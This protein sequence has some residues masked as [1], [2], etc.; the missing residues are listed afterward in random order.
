MINKKLRILYLTSK[1]YPDIGGTEQECRN[2]ATK[3]KE[4]GHSCI[5][6]TAY[7]DELPA[8]ELIDGIP[9]YRKIRGWHFFEIT[10][11]LSVFLL[12]F[13]YRNYFDQL[14]CFGFARFT[15]PAVVF[16]RLFRKKIYYRIESPGSFRQ[17][18]N[19]K[20]GRL[21]HRISRYAHGAIVFNKEV[22]NMLERMGFP[23]K[24]IYWIPNSVDTDRFTSVPSKTDSSVRFCFVGRLIKIKGLDFFIEALN[25]LSKKTRY[26]KVLI[27]GDGEILEALSLQVEQH[28]LGDIVSFPGKTD[29][30]L[31]YYQKSDVFVLP[32]VSEG[33]PLAM[34][35][36][37]SCGLC[38]LGSSV[39]GIKELMGDKV[40]DDGN[41][42]Y[43]ICQNGILF[44]PE[45]PK[46]IEQAML[47]VMGDY[48]LRKRLSE[49][50]RK[51]VL[52]NYSINSVADHYLR[53]FIK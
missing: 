5:V 39:G 46:S 21:I 15:A 20:Y 40:C 14:L 51:S 33:M 13:K 23:R 18:L 1:F 28:G 32:S 37:M 17:T 2:L 31:P 42:N 4:M 8:Y 41:T 25:I 16:C 26:L 43:Q 3:F 24:K 6:L 10:Y 47:R 27:I 45:N 36:A 30:V 49:N 44:P 19:L 22:Q 50:A 53:L 9:V 11:I 29:N 35:E 12:L 7:K 48:P 38:C 52:E 34:L